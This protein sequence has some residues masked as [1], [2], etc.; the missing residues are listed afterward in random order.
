MQKLDV[1]TITK[2]GRGLAKGE[3]EFL[4]LILLAVAS[5]KPCNNISLKSSG[6][7]SCLSA[8]LNFQ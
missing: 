4:Q 7:E 5:R 6:E 2:R 8:L 1:A 3:L